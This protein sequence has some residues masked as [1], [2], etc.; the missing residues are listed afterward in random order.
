MIWTIEGPTNKPEMWDGSTEALPNPPKVETKVKMLVILVD[1][2]DN[3]KRSSVSNKVV[4][5]K[6]L[7]FIRGAFLG[8]L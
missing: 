7:Y 2:I 4:M 1:M 5:I 8:H 3:V 6:K